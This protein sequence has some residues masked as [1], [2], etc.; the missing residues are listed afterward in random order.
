MKTL[1][2]QET[3]LV[4]ARKIAEARQAKRPKWSA[5]ALAKVLAENGALGLDPKKWTSRIKNYELARSNPPQEALAEIAKALGVDRHWF[6][7]PDGSPIRW[8]SMPPNARFE[9][10]ANAPMTNLVPYWGLVPCGNW[11]RP[12]IDEEELI[13]VSDRIQDLR[14][15]VA[16]RIAGNSMLPVFQPNQVVSVRL[17]PTPL[18]GVVTLAKNQDGELTLKILRHVGAGQ[19]ELHS[20]NPDYGVATA[21]SWEILGHAIYQEG[22]DPSGI[23]A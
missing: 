3:T 13:E 12:D 22:G 1:F 9:R 4:Y 14:R 7:E 10:P 19:Y 17:D 18:D 21:E 8:V 16:V 11:E 2:V 20:L 23:R 5:P 15:V 6:D